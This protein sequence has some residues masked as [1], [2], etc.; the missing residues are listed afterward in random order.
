M[1]LADTSIWIAHLRYGKPE[2]AGLLEEGQVLS[3]PFVAGELA[4][5][6][7]AD[8][9]RILGLLDDLPQALMAENDQVR[10]LIESKRLFGRGLGWIDAHL[11]AS[12]ALMSVRI[13]TLD[14]PL[15]S[16]ADAIGVLSDSTP[17]T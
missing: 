9:R 13:R 16:A 11:L 14:G 12:A 3:H 17:S 2:F 7:I 4:C 1:I 6:S 5:G 15:A 10:W 8:R